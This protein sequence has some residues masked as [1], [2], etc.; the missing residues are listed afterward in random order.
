MMEK[1]VERRKVT[2]YKDGLVWK[3][4]HVDEIWIPVD[5]KVL[6][7]IPDENGFILC[8]LSLKRVKELN[9]QDMRNRL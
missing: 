3:T 6:S 8:N 2:E 1:L 9:Y 4:E 5:G 7:N